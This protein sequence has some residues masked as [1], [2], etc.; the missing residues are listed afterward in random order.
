MTL[1][2]LKRTVFESGLEERTTRAKKRRQVPFF[3]NRD[4]KKR[5][6][7]PPLDVK[8]PVAHLHWPTTTLSPSFTR[9]AGERCTARFLWRFSKLRGSRGGGRR[10]SPPTQPSIAACGRTDDYTSSNAAF[11]T[12]AS[13]QDFPGGRLTL[14]PSVG[15][16]TAGTCECSEGSHG[17]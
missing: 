15:P 8:T 17:G 6:C 1:S 16:R 14:Q 4:A 5:V 2:T 3:P 11:S 10:V 7:C 13:L 12:M 9:N